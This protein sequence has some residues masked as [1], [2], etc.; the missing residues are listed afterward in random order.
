MVML[1]FRWLLV[2]CQAATIVITWPLW[3]VHET[4]PML[5]ALPLPALP[6]GPALLVS[7]ALVLVRA[8]GGTVL[9]SAL[10]VYAML[11]DQTRIQPEIVSLAVLLWGTFPSPDAKLVGRTHLIALWSRAGLSKLLSPEFLVTAGYGPLAV[12]VPR[13][14][15]WI[16]PA[17]GYLMAVAELAP[18]SS[19]SRRAR[20]G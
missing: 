10:L 14:L 11:I 8:T 16:R 6:L 1:A 19:R 9:H 13:S 5:P 7:L 12:L 15:A 20:V 3:R 2:G 4:S 18:A 17:G